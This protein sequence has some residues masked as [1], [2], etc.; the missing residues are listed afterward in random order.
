MEPSN[1]L[2]SVMFLFW[3]SSVRYAS[4]R[5]K[6]EPASGLSV[7]AFVGAALDF[8]GRN[9]SVVGGIP[10]RKVYAVVALFPRQYLCSV[11][12][13]LVSRIYTKQNLKQ[14]HLRNERDRG[15]ADC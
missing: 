12:R 15:V 3:T 9:F 1:P 7:V 6:D 14:R 8:A 11:Q 10:K 2:V 13:R 4:I 5:R